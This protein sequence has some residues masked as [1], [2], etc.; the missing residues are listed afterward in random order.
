VGLGGTFTPAGP[1]LTGMGITPTLWTCNSWSSTPANEALMVERCRADGGFAV[2][3]VLQG[4]VK[5]FTCGV[6]GLR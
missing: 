6:G 2:F 4:V 3:W 1:D 5:A